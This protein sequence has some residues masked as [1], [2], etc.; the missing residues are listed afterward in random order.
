[1]AGNYL[2]RKGFS[3]TLSILLTLT[4]LFGSFAASG[5]AAAPAYGADSEGYVTVR[6]E[7][8][9]YG[10]DGTDTNIGTV[11]DETMVPLA[12]LIAE[13]KA[14]DAIDK[15]L[16]I[17]GL[18]AAVVSGP[19][20]MPVS[21]AGV[22]YMDGYDWSFIYNDVGAFNGISGQP[23][24]NGDRI[25]MYLT[26]NYASGNYCM[27][28]Y[29]SY[30]TE[31]TSFFDGTYMPYA[32]VDLILKRIIPADWMTTFTD[33]VEVVGGADVTVTAPGG[34]ENNF[35]CSEKTDSENGILSFSAWGVGEY[36]ISATKTVDGKNT[37]SR[38]YCKITLTEDA[39]IINPIP[40][41]SDTAIGSLQLIFEGISAIDA[42]GYLNSEGFSVNH[43]V[44]S[45]KLSAEANDANASIAVNYKPA[46]G[47]F[48][49]YDLASM[50]EIDLFQ[51]ENT[52]KIILANG[53]DTQIYTL[54]IIRMP[55][56]VRDISSEVNAVINGVKS[57]KGFQ[58]VNDWILAM[59]AAELPI[60][61]ADKQEY[62][63][64]VLPLINNFADSGA[65]SVGSM[66]KIA[67]SL[68]SMGIDVRQIAD[69][70]VDDASINLFDLIANYDHAVDQYSAPYVLSL[71]DL[72]DSSGQNTYILPESP[73]VT[74]ASLLTAILG[75]Q[76]NVTGLFGSVDYTGMVL[77][78]LAPYYLSH[79]E[80]LNGVDINT[81]KASVNEALTGL[82]QKQSIDGG[83]GARNSNTTSTAIIGLTA[84]NINPHANSSF[85]KS[86]SS[87]ITDLLSFRTSD[88]KLGYTSNTSAND[89]ASLQ[90][91][92]ALAAYRNLTASVN[93]NIYGFIADVNVYTNWPDAELLTGIAVTKKPDKT[94]YNLN[95]GGGVNA[96]ADTT[97]LEVTAY[98]NGN[99]SNSKKLEDGY[100]ISRID[101]S[102]SG[103]KTV[104]VTYQGQ[105]ATFNVT[106][107]DA[108]GNI[109]SEKTVKI[110]VKSSGKG[111]IASN[112]AYAIE[113]GVT[114]VMDVLKAVLSAA[115]KTYVIQGGIYVSEIDGLSEFSGGA[116]S[117]W[118][119][120]VNGIDPVKAADS[121]KLSGGENIQWIYT[122]DYTKEP[123]SE[124]WNNQTAPEV[125][126]PL[127]DPDVLKWPFADVAQDDSINW[128]YSPVK[129]VYEKGLFAGT[130][131]TTFSPD[132][133]FTR[134]MLVTVLARHAGEISA[135]HSLQPF[136]DVIADSWYGSSVAWAK[137]V[138]IISG[139]KN[140]D[141]S[142]SFKPDA[143]ISR[144]D[145]AVIIDNYNRL[146]AKKPFAQ[147]EAVTFVDDLE[148]AQ[149]ARA[150]VQ[151]MQQA[152]II[153]GIK[154]PDGSFYFNPISNATRAEAA[155]M[156]YNMLIQ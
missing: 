145:V 67:I 6:I 1:M 95:E 110:T 34:N 38:P 121:Y 56:L 32:E 42:K 15:A 81:I 69:P 146:V 136:N 120:Y 19:Y 156:I 126:P 117:G 133:P 13:P 90:G 9:G 101:T 150:S 74:R 122:L 144:Q 48:F 28:P 137:E 24:E 40:K 55:E 18:D 17:N 62:L 148:I 47:S 30:F 31:K 20:D 143:N 139:Y 23:I 96:I 70:D 135:S 152:G 154:N 140:P 49:E 92:Q 43:A 109:P 16:E 78:A 115:G 57:I 44:T 103:T 97:G 124:K 76:D 65:G 12:D 142:Y 106:V 151:S 2:M 77:P 88:D 33:G 155:V 58:P 51:G 84:L 129:Y 89:F 94:T 27:D 127:E 125:N 66:A 82:S 11:M 123:G 87:L 118:M 21:F 71:Y 134:A 86:G 75:S 37:I 108:G 113:P 54:V 4:M 131:E 68:T 107:K 63:S 80:D 153:S 59:K 147:K 35:T 45:A 114:T 41:A 46:G 5:L 36:V 112:N 73:K 22:T 100:S 39:V 72:K 52:F 25:V 64:A 93:S 10:T 104:T 141:G 119:Y 116:N 60:S 50:A 91:F 105:T 83:F 26:A 132:S 149:Y 53:T 29:H 8:N 7:G 85:I 14:I 98:Y 128:F 61:V 3:R 102:S 130:S 111:T 138:G 99:L 79:A